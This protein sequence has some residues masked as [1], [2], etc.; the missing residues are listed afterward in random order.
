MLLDRKTLDLFGRVLFEK[1][2]IRPPHK[3][4][5]PMLNEACLLYVI[6][7][8][9]R[10]ASTYGV[11]NVQAREAAL[12]KCG[13]YYV[14]ITPTEKSAKYESVA[15]HFYPEILKR[16][17][18]NTVPPIFIARANPI[19]TSMAK[20]KVDQ[21]LQKY[22]DQILLYF[23]Y[24]DLTNEDLLV[25]KLKELFLILGNTDYAPTIREILS[26]L[27]EPQTANFKEIIETHLLSNLA[28]NELAHLTNLSISTFKRKFQRIYRDSPGRYFRN[29]KLEK[30]TT[31]LTTSHRS[32]S[33]IA[34]DC[35]YNDLPNFTSAFK[36]KYGVPP[37]LYRK[38]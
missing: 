15:V 17:Y 36:E 29:K 20:I 1:I 38:P 10:P 8:S 4:P 37:S 19:P 28:I 2:I 9:I 11:M 7:G 18:E 14:H 34:F 27:F 3:Q 21:L 25:I 22:F 6:R 12:M 13:T 16:V 31:L 26:H 30:A 23:S 33:E 35:G 32:V 24:P 5:Y